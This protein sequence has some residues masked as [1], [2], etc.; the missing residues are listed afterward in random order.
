MRSVEYDI[1]EPGSGDRS[2]PRPLLCFRPAIEETSMNAP[3]NHRQLAPALVR[4]PVAHF[5]A[6]A[7]V[8]GGSGQSLPMIDPSTGQAFASIARGNA[9]DIDAAVSAASAARDG[10]WGRTAP[11]EKGRLLA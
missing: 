2:R 7:W 10:A 6:N 1:G 11:A 5:I 3:S 4:T 8:A 9:A